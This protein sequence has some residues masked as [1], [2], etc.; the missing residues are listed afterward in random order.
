MN[1]SLFDDAHYWNSPYDD[2]VFKYINENPDLVDDIETLYKRCSKYLKPSLVKILDDAEV[3]DSLSVKRAK[4][5]LQTYDPLVLINVIRDKDI[6][7]GG[8]NAFDALE[9][10]VNHWDNLFSDIILNKSLNAE[11]LTIK[12]MTISTNV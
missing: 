4:Y 11:L 3:V 8:N 10:G 9:Y 5:L 2:A 1:E 12:T 6:T 7:F